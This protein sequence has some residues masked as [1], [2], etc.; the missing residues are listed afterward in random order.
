MRN[1]EK[2]ISWLEDN[3]VIDFSI[4][5]SKSDRG[6]AEDL[7]GDCLQLIKNRKD[8]KSKNFEEGL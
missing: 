1:I 2:L 7:A 6:T 8:G 4:T 3:S 5:L